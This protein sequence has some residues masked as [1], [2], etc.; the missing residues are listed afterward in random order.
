MCQIYSTYGNSDKDW[1]KEEM[2]EC[3]KKYYFENRYHYE[4]LD[5]W[6]HIK[7]F[8]LSRKLIV[9]IDAGHIQI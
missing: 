9:R 8:Y 4:K 2:N 7:T 3:P 6:D 1:I 5:L